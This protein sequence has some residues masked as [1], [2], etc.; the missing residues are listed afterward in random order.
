MLADLSY[1]EVA[2][3]AGEMGIYAG[4]KALYHSTEPMR[5][6]LARLGV[7][8]EAG[9]VPFN[10]WVELPGLALLA[11]K[12]HYEAEG[13]C[14]HWA[15]FSRKEGEPVV[16]DPDAGLVVNRR[17]DFTAIEPRWFIRIK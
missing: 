12:R 5:R 13:A 2:A 11:S 3:I 8:A 15:V 9:E 17:Y 7:G 16:L 14:W 6:L 10:G 4:D 1:F